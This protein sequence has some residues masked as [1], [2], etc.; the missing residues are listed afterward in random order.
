M[1]GTIEV[2]GSKKNSEV[3]LVM[4]G[5]FK[6]SLEGSQPADRQFD[7]SGSKSNPSPDIIGFQLLVH[8]SA[9]ANLS[10]A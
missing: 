7:M 3:V 4:Q 9:V 10:Q 6:Q 5:V 1:R 8:S 2:Q